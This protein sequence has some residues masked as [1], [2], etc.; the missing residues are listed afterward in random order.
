[1]SSTY[2]LIPD[3]HA[4]SY[5]NNDRADWLSKLIIDIKPDV[6]IN[7][8]DAADLESLSSYDKGKRSFQGKSYKA[9]LNAH[10]EFQ[11]RVWEPVKKTKKKLPHSVFLE[12]NHEHRIERAL[13]LSPEMTGV[14]GFDDFEFDVYYDEIV[15]Y[16]GGLPGIYKRDEIL[17]AHFFPTGISGRPIGGER[18][19]HMLLAKNGISSIAAHSH[20]LDFATRRTV[21]DTH[22][23]GLVVGCY[24]DY[25]NPWAGPIGKFWQAGIPILRNVENGKFDFQWIS[26]EAMKAEY[27]N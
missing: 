19:A 12:G 6:V 1:L 14:I 15:R 22:L 9:D 27:G 3:Q 7:M 24:Q 16:D 20:T 18:P 10:L 23:N 2:L 26:I 25:I 8:G 11:E 4:V 21:A 17:F 13:D 5:H